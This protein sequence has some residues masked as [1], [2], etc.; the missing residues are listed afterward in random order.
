MQS[1][2][3]LVIRWKRMDPETSAIIGTLIRHALT[4]AGGYMVAHQWLDSGQSQTLTVKLTGAAMLGFPVVWGAL[5]KMDF[6]WSDIFGSK[7]LKGKLATLQAQVDANEK[8]LHM[9]AMDVSAL[10]PNS[11]NQAL[12]TPI[13]CGTLAGVTS[14]PYYAGGGGAG[15]DTNPIWNWGTPKVP[16]GII[17]H[18]DVGHTGAGGGAGVGINPIS[19]IGGG[20]VVDRGPLVMSTGTG[21]ASGGTLPLAGGSGTW[22]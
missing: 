19:A 8:S 16:D 5:Q 10:R 12:G 9:L 11:S 20:G 18:T 17:R 2:T 1:N 22:P 21:Q 3:V 14:Q 4:A 13:K 6:N 15:V 7:Q